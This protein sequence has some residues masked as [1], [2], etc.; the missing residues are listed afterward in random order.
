MPR[1]RDPYVENRTPSAWR[2]FWRYGPDE[3]KVLGTASERRLVGVTARAFGRPPPSVM[4]VAT[5][6]RKYPPFG[7]TVA[8]AFG[9]PITSHYALCGDLHAEQGVAVCIRA[10]CAHRPPGTSACS[11][12]A[13]TCSRVVGNTGIGLSCGR[14]RSSISVQPRTTPS[15]PAC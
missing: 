6:T 14:M 15:A 10:R 3:A 1:S 9:Q 13:S 5:H 11:M 2:I 4:S 12:A 8:D 7:A